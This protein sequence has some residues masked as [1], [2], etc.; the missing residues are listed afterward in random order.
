MESLLQGIGA[1]AVLWAVSAGYAK[2]VEHR[3]RSRHVDQEMARL[4]AHLAEHPEDFDRVQQD[5]HSLLTGKLPT[6]F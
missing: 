2:Y 3:E 6:R 1:L 5:L 4:R